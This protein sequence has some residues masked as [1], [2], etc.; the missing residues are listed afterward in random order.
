MARGERIKIKKKSRESGAVLVE[1][2]LAIAV[3][4]V[5]LTP[6]T[7]L[8]LSSRRTTALAEDTARAVSLAKGFLEELLARGPTAW[9][10]EELAPVPGDPFFEREVT[11]TS[12]PSGL[13]EIKVS[14]K[15]GQGENEKRIELV[16]LA[17]PKG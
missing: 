10:D 11:V 2:L 4:S 17:L 15:W 14:V 3:L 12:R 6:L 5:L 13:R 9:R 7:S 16:T 1:I 8:T